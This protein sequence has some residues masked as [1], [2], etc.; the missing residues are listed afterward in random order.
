MSDFRPLFDGKTLDGWR[1]VPRLPTPRRPYDPP[2]SVAPAEWQRIIDHTGDWTVE[3][4][5]IC[6]RQSPP[7]SGLGGYLI[8]DEIFG[9]FELVFEAQPDWPAD[10]GIMLRTSSTATQGY[11]VLLDHR[12]SGNIGGFYG[13]GIGRFHAINFNIDAR[14]DASGHPVGLKLEDPATTIEPITDHKRSLLTK[15]VTGAQFLGIWKWSEWNE[16]RI[17]VVGEIPVI[18][19]TINGLEIAQLDASQLPPE[20]FDPVATL[21]LLGRRG[22]IAFEVHDN[23][24]TLKEGRWGP[25]AACK[26]RNIRLRDIS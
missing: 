14:R 12:Q 5:A 16:F 17:S 20:D 26:W 22:H 23:D 21:R 11:Q 15:S 1:A 24:P 13:N 3:D 18:T 10:T 19:T 8:S 6:G 2:I 9:D 7:G 4:G 25:N